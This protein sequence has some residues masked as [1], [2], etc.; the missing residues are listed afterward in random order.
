LG[1]LNKNW[2]LHGIESNFSQ[3]C[4]EKLKKKLCLLKHAGAYKASHGTLK[5]PVV[6]FNKI[7]LFL[8]FFLLKSL[9]EF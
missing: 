4:R 1:F 9:G 6:R 7:N 8:I 2:R 5:D 3:H